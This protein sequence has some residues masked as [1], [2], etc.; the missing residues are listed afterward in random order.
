MNN[1]ATRLMFAFGAATAG[2]ILAA[3][4]ISPLPTWWQLTF[5]AIGSF[6]GFCITAAVDESRSNQ[7][8]LENKVE[9][10]EHTLRHMEDAA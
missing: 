10:L 5:T 2:L 9:H 1:L 8:Y 4:W 7:L 6:V 3:I